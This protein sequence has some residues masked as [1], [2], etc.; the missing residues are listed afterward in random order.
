MKAGKAHTVLVMGKGSGLGDGVGSDPSPV[1]VV[2]KLGAKRYCMSFGG[3]EK[4]KVGKKATLQNAPVPGAC[5][6]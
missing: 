1:D 3:T 6:P 5:P 4:L 2:L